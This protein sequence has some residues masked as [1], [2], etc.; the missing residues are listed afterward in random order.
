[1][2]QLIDGPIVTTPAE[3]Q[4]R[5]EAIRALMASAALDVSARACASAGLATIGALGRPSTS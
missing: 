3:A 4:R 2:D 5:A 1:M